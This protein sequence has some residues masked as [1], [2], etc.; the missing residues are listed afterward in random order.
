MNGPS[1]QEH[2]GARPS[3]MKCASCDVHVEFLSLACEGFW[4]S[5]CGCKVLGS[6]AGSIIIGGGLCGG[7]RTLVR[8]RVYWWT[9]LLRARCAK[10][11]RPTLIGDERPFADVCQHPGQL[12]QG[13]RHG[14][15]RIQE[16]RFV[17]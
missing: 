8:L 9:G 1:A 15:T 7:G 10:G 16:C 4:D 13:R 2:S 12:A 17:L 5:L 11:A 14:I 3:H 6:V